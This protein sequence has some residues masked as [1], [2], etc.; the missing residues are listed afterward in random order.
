MRGDFVN[1][2]LP[3]RIFSRW[4]CLS[5]GRGRVP[6]PCGFC[7]GGDFRTVHLQIPAGAEFKPPPFERRKGWG[8]HFNF[9]YYFE[10]STNALVCGFAGFPGAYCAARKSG[11]D[12]VAEFLVRQQAL[13]LEREILDGGDDTSSLLLR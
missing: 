1:G 8:T 13:A 2:R 4:C 9:D 10:F 5:G 6:H 7:K 11:V 12:D 3:I